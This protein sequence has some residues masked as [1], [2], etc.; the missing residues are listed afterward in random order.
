MYVLCHVRAL[1][2]LQKGQTQDMSNRRKVEHG[3]V[4]RDERD[5]PDSSQ[6]EDALRVVEKAVDTRVGEITRWWIEEEVSA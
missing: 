5:A 2:K 4:P 6:T 3:H 1:H